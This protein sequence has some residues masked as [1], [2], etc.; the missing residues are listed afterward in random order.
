MDYIIRDCRIGDLAEVITLCAHHA[1][2]EK[3]TYSPEG[4]TEDL[5]KALFS[6]P[7]SL[8]CRVVE[9]DGK[10]SG[11]VTF[12]FNYST[13]GGGH[14]LYMDCLFLEPELRSMGIG[15]E[16]IA[17]LKKVAKERHCVNI[18]WQTPAF[19]ERAIRFYKRI[20]GVGKDKVRFFLDKEKF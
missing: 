2:F 7:P 18:Q 5:K 17:G 4:K 13:W 19:N 16:I 10:V 12:T 8:Y 14:F 9:V 15:T 11:Y 6:D 20:G 1:A 3:A